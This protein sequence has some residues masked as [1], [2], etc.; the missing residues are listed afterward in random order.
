[1]EYPLTELHRS[2]YEVA[3]GYPDIRGW[4]ILNSAG[5]KFG[6]VVELIF[7]PLSHSVRY[8]V[9]HIDGKPI[10]LISR[11]VLLPIGLAEL[12]EESGIVYVPTVTVGQLAT[13][14]TYKRSEF[15]RAF[16]RNVRGVFSGKA[17]ETVEEE[18][19]ENTN[20]EFYEHD[21][22]NQD[23]F[24]QK[25]K[26]HTVYEAPP[27]EPGTPIHKENRDYQPNRANDPGAFAPFREGTIELTEHAEI[28][29]VN[30]EA[31]VVEEIKVN[32]ETSERNET[33]RDKIRR[34][35]VDIE[36]IPKD[37]SH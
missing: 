1:M 12:V 17:A 15:N 23:R 32:K 2:G 10:N 8:L 7:D 18:D 22:F 34:T 29:V 6:E 11:D 31:R 37:E 26:V 21:H 9:V 28:P 14:P 20:P 13:L 19:D 4:N 30:K 3:D 36:R 16:E 5:Q 35:E 25:R 24:Y 33:I 27:P